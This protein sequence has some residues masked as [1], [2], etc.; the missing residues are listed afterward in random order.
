[1]KA[2]LGWYIQW[3]QGWGEYYK[4]YAA[5]AIMAVLFSAVITLLFKARDRFLAWQKGLIRW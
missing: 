5:L 3:A 2:G 4:I 1:M